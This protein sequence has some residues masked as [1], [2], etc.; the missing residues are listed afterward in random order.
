MNRVLRSERSMPSCQISKQLSFSLGLGF[1]R[2]L[3]RGSLANWPTS[4]TSCAFFQSLN[5]LRSVPL[6]FAHLGVNLVKTTG[7]T[8]YYNMNLV[9]RSAEH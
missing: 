6:V 3:F 5:C 9:S 8:P 7:A 2:I 4:T 1:T